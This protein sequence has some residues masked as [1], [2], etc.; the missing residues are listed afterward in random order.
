MI[1]AYGFG[2]ITVDGKK[3][4]SDVIIYPERT[5]EGWWRV[6]GHDLCR[7]DIEQILEFDAF[8]V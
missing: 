3:Y 7:E 5:V 6:S 2:R 4:R 8:G 1:D